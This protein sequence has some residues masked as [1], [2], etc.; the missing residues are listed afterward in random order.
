MQCYSSRDLANRM[1]DSFIHVEF[2]APYV[3]LIYTLAFVQYSIQ[4]VL[5]GQGLVQVKS[6][7]DEAMMML[8]D[9]KFLTPFTRDLKHSRWVRM[10]MIIDMQC[11]RGKIMHSFV[12]MT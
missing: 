8:G 5:E 6:D 1:C 3:E 10:L 7:L 4:V 11:D 9:G 12:T 2:H